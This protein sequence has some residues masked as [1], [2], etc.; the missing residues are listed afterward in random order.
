[1]AGSRDEEETREHQV[2]P[3]RPPLPD[4]PAH[5][6]ARPALRPADAP[7]ASPTPYPTGWAPSA[8]P[9]PTSHW[10]TPATY[11][12]TSAAV[13]LAAIVLLVAGLLA[14][15]VG[16]AIIVA[17]SLFTAVLRD[18]GTGSFPFGSAPTEFFDSAAD[19]FRI[20]G[21]VTLVGGLLH[22]IAAIG[23]FAHKNWAR[24]LGVLLALLGTLLGAAGVYGAL[25]FTI[26]DGP[27][28]G[29]A[30]VVVFLVAY[31]FTLLALLLGG[32]HFSR[33]VAGQP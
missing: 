1:M 13:V 32:S 9:P 29:L 12:P 24:A 16:G 3:E 14:T 20:I 21:G 19:V 22:V 33:R 27:M 10:T 18:G 25:Y 6:P 7:G 31:A 8:Q 17:G 28:T 5:V 26:Q 15:L 11:Y 4:E 2:V 23:I 30:T